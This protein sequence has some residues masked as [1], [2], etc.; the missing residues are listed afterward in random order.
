MIKK[1]FWLILSIITALVIF[2]LWIVL[3]P[4]KTKTFNNIEL[5][6]IFIDDDWTEYNIFKPEHWAAKDWSFLFEDLENSGALLSWDEYEITWDLQE[7]MTW[8]SDILAIKNSELNND[9][10]G[11][12]S[13]EIITWIVETGNVE[14]WNILWNRDYIWEYEAKENLYITWYTKNNIKYID[15]INYNWVK[16]LLSY[17]W[18]WDKEMPFT[19]WDN[20]NEY[21][22]PKWAVEEPR[23]KDCETPWWTNIRHNE[24]ILAYEQR[25]D[26]PDICNVQ[27]RVC[28]NWK[29]SWT[30]T[31]A[32]CDESVEV[33]YTKL[34][35]TT[36]ND[37]KF[38]ELIQTPKYSEKDWANYNSNWKILNDT[39]WKDPNT[40]WDNND[41]DWDIWEYNSVE[42]VNPNYY[43][44]ISP[45]W[46]IVQHGQFVKAY[47]FPYWFTNAECRVELRLCVD[48]ELKWNYWYQK[49]DYLDITYEEYNRIITGNINWGTIINSWNASVNNQGSNTPG[50]LSNRW[51]RYDGSTSYTWAHV[52]NQPGWNWTPWSLSSWSNDGQR[53]GFTWWR[54]NIWNWNNINTW[55]NLWGA[56]TRTWDGV[57]GRVWT[58][59]N[60]RK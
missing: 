43:N 15:I 1:I 6:Y 14:K 2:F 3:I 5:T 19:W 48:W 22:L 9:N 38:N 32:S 8:E 45:W 40:I 50:S 56:T 59:N 37:E 53:H 4:M 24:W 18:L 44:C 42:Q 57:P 29:L 41:K 12:N 16:I 52:N 10:T 60:P 13:W 47:V 49:C 54:N 20:D 11:E 55:N 17:L 58:T 35:F 31:Q 39:N 51:D 36:K 25:K 46:E 23:Y 30:F 28:K 21:N 27:K 33:E 34:W 7:N 26:S